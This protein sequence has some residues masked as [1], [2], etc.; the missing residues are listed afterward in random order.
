M[1]KLEINLHRLTSQRVFLRFVEWKYDLFGLV[2]NYL[3]IFLNRHHIPVRL[4][5]CFM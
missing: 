3:F 4:S 5:L 1:D 2:E